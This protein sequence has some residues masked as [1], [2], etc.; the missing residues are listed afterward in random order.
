[1]T[2]KRNKIEA[3]YEKLRLEY[4]FENGVDFENRVIRISGSIGAAGCAFE[5]VDYFD[6]NFLDAALSEMER[7]S[8]EQVTI[9]INSP[10][11]EVY[12]ALA[13]V[14]RMNASS[15]H[16]VTEGYGAVMSAATL[17][18]MGGHHRRLSHYA[19]VMFHEMSYGTH[20]KHEDVKEQV[21]QSEKEQKR[22]AS[23][24]EK[25]S[26]KNAK[27]WV[28]KMKKKEYYPLPEEMLIYGAIDELI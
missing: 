23:Y 7:R 13:M 5:E 22:W 24:Y 15:C 17:I 28:S 11:G 3:E 8:N 6:F 10:G 12:E 1:M 20:G 21:Q 26:D 18:L 19:V 2:Q 27:F 4:L 16:I 25:F 14:G 9:R